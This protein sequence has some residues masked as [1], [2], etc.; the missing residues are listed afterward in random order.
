MPSEKRGDNERLFIGFS[1]ERMKI[2][3]N[4]I[5]FINDIVKPYSSYAFLYAKCII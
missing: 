1:H 5:Y 2:F 4:K 3:N